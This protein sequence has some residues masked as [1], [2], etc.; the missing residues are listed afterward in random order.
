MLLNTIFNNLYFLS[1]S[2]NMKFSEEMDVELQIFPLDDSP[3][4]HEVA[5]TSNIPGHQTFIFLKKKPH[6][7]NSQFYTEEP[8]KENSAY[9]M[10]TKGM[11]DG[12]VP[13]KLA[14]K[15]AMI[16]PV[17][18]YLNL[19][20]YFSRVWP[21]VYQVIKLKIDGMRNEGHLSQIEHHLGFYGAGIIEPNP[22]FFDENTLLL[23]QVNSQD[24][25]NKVQIILQRDGKQIELALSVMITLAKNYASLSKIVKRFQESS[26]R[27][28][29]SLEETA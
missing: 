27:K 17:K 26:K 22:V 7:M 16:L 14:M 25:D 28:R 29:S 20:F 23:I 8:M 9:L 10:T 6:K 24:L 18:V 11:G 2:V 3:I 5:A 12:H 15:E 21:K 1:F 19:L 4:V 13:F